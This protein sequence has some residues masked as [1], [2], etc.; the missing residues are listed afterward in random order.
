M[1]RF[2]R[3]DT[4]HADIVAAFRSCGAT[5]QSLAAIGNGCP[6]LL[7]GWRQRNLLVEVKRD[8]KAKLTP[9]QEKW[10]SA[11]RGPVWRVDSREDAIAL[12]NAVNP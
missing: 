3:V 11:W 10:L 8:K 9:D 4:N 12:L 2:A 7:V 5:V 6:D 1:R